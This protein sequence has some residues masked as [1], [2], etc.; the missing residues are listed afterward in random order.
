MT[1]YPDVK[2]YDRTINKMVYIIFRIIEE[3]F[4]QSIIYEKNI[5]IILL[6]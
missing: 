2:S 3:Y 6:T 5:Y 4:R 1:D